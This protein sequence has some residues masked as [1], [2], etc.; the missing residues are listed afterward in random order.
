MNEVLVVQDLSKKIR[1]RASF[2]CESFFIKSL[3]FYYKIRS[4]KKLKE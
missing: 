2:L 1:R 3:K 4:V